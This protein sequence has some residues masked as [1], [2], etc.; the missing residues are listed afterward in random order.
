MGRPTAARCQRGAARQAHLVEHHQGARRAEAL[1][2]LKR[3]KRKKEEEEQGA[4]QPL[5]TLPQ[6]VSSEAA[7]LQEHLVEPHQEVRRAG[8]L[9]EHI[10][11]VEK[12][13]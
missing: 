7:A 3:G 10:I 8:A 11:Q 1:G 4:G 9:D 6:H 13:N 2:T 5:D 12:L